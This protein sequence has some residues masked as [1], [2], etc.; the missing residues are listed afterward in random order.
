MKKKDV[1]VGKTYLVKVSGS[2]V[3]VRL[4]SESPYGGWDGVNTVTGR[5]VRVKTA[6]RLRGEHKPVLVN[7]SESAPTVAEQV[8]A[9]V[10]KLFA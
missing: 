10:A 2:V 3:P 5:S 6:G 4:K 1:V 9:D 7:R 8:R